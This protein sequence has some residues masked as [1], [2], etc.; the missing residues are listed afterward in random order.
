MSDEPR[1]R[2][3]ALFIRSLGA[4]GAGAERI[5]L[6]LAEAFAARG[7]RV[8]LV[9]GRREGHLAGAVPPGVRVVDLAV[10]SPLPLVGAALR[11]PRSARSLA[12]ALAAL[13]PPWILAAVPALAAYLAR[14]RP[15][16]LLSALS[17]S[18]LAALW[19]RER[20]GVPVRVAVSEH[21]T[22]SVRSRARA[23]A[24]LARAA[25]RGGALV[26]A[27]RR[28]PRGVG[29]RRRRP[30]AHRGAAA[31]ADHRH[32]QPRG[33]ATRSTRPRAS[34]S[35]TRGC[36]PAS[37][38]S[39]SASA[40]CRR[41]RAS[42]C[43]CARSRACAPS[44]RARLVILGEGPQRR[45]LERLAREL[46]DRRTTSR[47]RASSRIRS[48]GWR[49]SAVF[50]L[51]SRWEGLP[52][53]LIEAL[54]CGCAGG[55]HAIV[56]AGPR[57]SSSA[58]G[59]GRSCRSAM[60][61]RSAR[62]IA[63]ALSLAVRSRRAPRARARLHRGSRRAALSRRAAARARP[64]TRTRRAGPRRPDS[65]SRARSRGPRARAARAARRR[66]RATRAPPPSRA[67]LRA[68]RPFWPGWIRSAFMPTSLPTAGTPAAMYW[69]SLYAHFPRD[70]GSSSASGMMP[71]SKL[72]T[73]SASPS[74]VQRTLTTRQPGSDEL[75]VAHAHDLERDAA[76]ELRERARRARARS[77]GWSRARP[78]R[79]ET[80]TAI[81]AR[82]VMRDVERHRRGHDRGREIAALRGEERVAAGR[83]VRARERARE[84]GRAPVARPRAAQPA[85]PAPHHRVVEVVD[86]RGG[87]R[88]PEARLARRRARAV[89]QHHVARRDRLAQRARARSRRADT[90]SRGTRSRAPRGAAP[91]GRAGSASTRCAPSR[92]RGGAS[93]RREASG[94]LASLASLVGA[95]TRRMRGTLGA[96]R[97]ADWLRSASR[98]SLAPGDPDRVRH[99]RPA[100]RC[101]AIAVVLAVARWSGAGSA[102]ALVASSAAALAL[103][104]GVLRASGLD[105][106]IYYRFHERF[107][108]WDPRHGHRAYLPGVSWQALEPHGDLQV[109]TREPIAEPRARAVPQRLGG[110]PQRRRLRGRA[111]GADRRFVRRGRRLHASPTSCRLRL[112]AR[113]DPR[114]QPR[115]PGRPARLRVVLAQLRRAPRPLVEAGAV[116]V[117]GQRFSRDGRRARAL[118]LVGRGR[119]RRARRDR[120]AHAPADLSRDALARRALH[121]ARRARRRA[122]GGASARGRAARVLEPRVAP[123][124]RDRARGHGAHGRGVRAPRARPRRGLLHPDQVPRLPALARARGAPAQRELAAPRPAVR[125]I[126]RAVHRSHARARGPLRGAARRGPLHLVARRHALE[127]RGDRRR[128]RARRG[129]AARARESAR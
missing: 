19:A 120:A 123:R 3:L 100:M 49:S 97:A 30:R 102:V 45:A 79:R 65:R 11:D 22:L 29:G 13:P 96:V 5:W 108:T 109:L 113:G 94:K 121:Q 4:N 86:A 41:R 77:G 82:R 20:A 63:R 44:A 26:P 88:A 23:R 9:L 92:R 47:C 116:P 105:Q 91:S 36:S 64:S 54:A 110:L 98:A 40:S 90:R 34:R 66:S 74:R 28:D 57:R 18:N 78:S 119:L 85:A 83:R 15:D 87:Q 70:H 51:S 32:A 80:A 52:S 1:E 106:A 14:E 37:R 81:G 95:A 56:R 118:R 46:G 42:T 115:A 124:A 35:I 125:G 71:A 38:R 59:S 24:A 107:A 12:P 21:N 122:G 72:A 69:S 101:V 89:D 104:A 75:A 129:G 31:R 39:C 103:Y 50:A 128:G 25:D 58:A 2:H 117:R 61:T 8:D 43:C 111:V 67:A 62:A 10:R 60:P 48:R 112:A 93:S 7:H 16:A 53:V 84:A 6:H 73:A 127:R 76:R 126:P 17:Y 68:S 27:R 55:E 33:H 114:L 99:R